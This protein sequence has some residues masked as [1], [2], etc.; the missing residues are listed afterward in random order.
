MMQKL[1][2]LWSFF[3]S[4]GSGYYHVFVEE[5]RTVMIVIGRVSL[6][7]VCL[8]LCQSVSLSVCL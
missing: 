3:R 4:V 1:N 5:Y 7:F 2:D 8:S 6:L